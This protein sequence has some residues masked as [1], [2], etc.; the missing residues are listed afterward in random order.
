[1]T[2]PIPISKNEPVRLK[3]C[4]LASC[5]AVCCYDGAYLDIDDEKRISTAMKHFPEFFVGV[6]KNPITEE[7]WRGMGSGRKTKTRPWKYV[8][9]IPA[10]FTE[11]RCVFG[12]AEGYCTL[13]TA[14]RTNDLHPWTFKPQVCYM[15][16][17][18]EYDLETGPIRPGEDPLNFG[19]DYPGYAT[20]IDCGKYQPDG[21]PWQEVLIEEI[22]TFKTP[23]DEYFEAYLQEL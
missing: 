7:N 9:A 18:H 13:E 14:A 1:M 23:I 22:E 10:H 8:R 21:H 6:P 19:K 3:R 2:E 5:E 11:T 4:D 12:D 15:F 20:Y 16:P 17:L